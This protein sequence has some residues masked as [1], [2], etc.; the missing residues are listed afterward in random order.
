MAVRFDA[1]GESYSRS[2]GLTSVTNWSVACWVKLAVDRA[3]TTVIWQI[4]DGAGANYLRVNAWNGSALTFQTTG[5]GWFGL[6]GRAL[7]VDEW[8]FI[9]LSATANPGQAR[10]RTRTAAS[11]A[12]VGGSPAQANVT[13]SAATLRIGDGQAA[14]EWLNGSI[15]AFKA[16][17][18]ALTMDELELESWTYLPYRPENL[19]AWYPFL[20]PDQNDASGNGQTL[21]GGTGSA[22]D[23]G[24][25]ISWR[26]GRHRTA[27]AVPDTVTGSLAGT[28]PA[29]TAS[30]S[31]AVTVSGALA[32]I[33]PAATANLAGQLD[34]NRL[35]GVLP[36]AT[37]SMAG[38]VTV[39]GAAAATLPAAAGAFAGDV[40]IP[41]NDITV[42][43]R[44]PV[45]GW[46]AGTP[47]TS[48][49]AGAAR[50]WKSGPP[51]T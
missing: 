20:R 11:A 45:R 17:N 27:I 9:G 13:V 2:L 44:G 22:L 12:F 23:D 3:A 37:A 35:A 42:T 25:P 10:V 43:S 14:N 28:L 40:E 34:T 48:W 49:R 1:D 5:N 33:A 50:S 19:R 16:W 38:T 4:D 6:M 7:A 29:A 32:G 31:A 41:T 47:E 24:P 46:T 39:S 15:A 21:S 36:A 26:T 18:V 30:A 8:T 51:T